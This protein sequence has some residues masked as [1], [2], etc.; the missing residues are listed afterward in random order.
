[1]VGLGVLLDGQMK[2]SYIFLTLVLLISPARAQLSNSD[3]L[4][5]C[6]LEAIVV[7]ADRSNSVLAFATNAASVLTSQEFQSLPVTNVSDILSMTPG[8]FFFN[9]DGLGSDPIATVRGFYGG[10]E[11]EY[12]LVLVDGKQL[13]DVETGL[14]NW[15]SMPLSSIE[16]IEVVRGGASSLYGDT[17]IGGVINI[18]TAGADRDSSIRSS[19]SGGSFDVFN[20]QL[21]V[22]A[23]WNGAD[24]SLFGAKEQNNGFRAHAERHIETVGGSFSLPVSSKG[25]VSL[26]TT[27]HWTRFDEP[28]VLSNSELNL[29]RTQSSAYYKFDHT[30]ERKHRAALDGQ[31]HPAKTIQL[32]VSLSG[33][34]RRADVIRTLLLSPEFADTK[35]RVL[36]TSRIEASS[37]LTLDALPF[38]PDSKLIVGT[39]AVFSSLASEYYKFFSGSL[40]EYNSVSASR[41]ALDEKGESDGQNL[42]GFFQYEL[43]PMPQLRFVLGVRFD[44]LKDSYDQ[45]PPSEVKALSSEHSAFNPK[46][47][48]NYRYLN[49]AN[50]VGNLYANVS[51]SFKAPTLDQLYDQR[52]IP[53]PFP[54]FEISLYNTGLK[55]QHGTSVEIGAYHWVAILPQ[56]LIGELSIAVYSMELKDEV[57]FDI[58]QFKYVNIGRSRHRGVELGANLY[59]HRW[60]TAFANITHQSVTS[61][62]G[63]ASGK[64][65]KAIPR[66]IIVAGIRGTHKSGLGG[67]VVDHIGAWNF[68]RR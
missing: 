12:L 28:G 9:R 7:T 21:R 64:F 48:L 42:A 59:I 40:S 56:S 23:S 6:Q 63:A 14:L 43:F 39:D 10:G 55:P 44:Y 38:L 20:A 2:A 41:G 25:S 30:T 22:D 61:R 60:A 37:Q 52:S 49:S 68:S 65:L 1:M 66:S 31:F 27:H 8:I 46:I 45:R 4:R 3:T 32:S 33:E 36:S 54:P 50:H 29:S 24:Y 35:N 16:S 26:S 15:N 47:G 11:A 19:I 17:A 58:Q 13:N 51:R 53:I 18:V 57:D 67:S 5:V 62:V 34:A